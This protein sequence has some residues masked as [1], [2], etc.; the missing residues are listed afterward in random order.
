VGIGAL[1]GRRS[2]GASDPVGPERCGK[3]A[4]VVVDVEGGENRFTAVFGDP[5]NFA[6]LAYAVRGFF[7]NGTPISRFDRMTTRRIL[8]IVVPFDDPPDRAAVH[9]HR[10]RRANRGPAHRG[11]AAR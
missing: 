5:L 8:D 6:Y 11:L 2:V 10:Y 9:I 7:D 3:L 4:Y 1:H